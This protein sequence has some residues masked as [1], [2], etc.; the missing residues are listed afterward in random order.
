MALNIPATRE[1]LRGI[2]RDVHAIIRKADNDCKRTYPLCDEATDTYCIMVVGWDWT[3]RVLGPTIYFRIHEGKLWIEENLV[4]LDFINER[5]YAQVAKEDI[6]LGYLS[7][8]ER[9]E[10]EEAAVA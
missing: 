10:S 5:I 8:E 4:E 3:G 2:V 1:L 6:V 9:N 7:E